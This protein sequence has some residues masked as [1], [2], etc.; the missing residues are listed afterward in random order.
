MPG[1]D[2]SSSNSSAIPPPSSTSPLKDD[3]PSPS[4]S[5]AKDSTATPVA[6]GVSQ[7]GAPEAKVGAAGVE[8]GEV[9]SSQDDDEPEADIGPASNEEVVDMEVF[10]QLLEIV[11][12]YL[13]YLSRTAPSR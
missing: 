9:I 13:A 8:T 4:N 2:A 1:P 12:S 5:L 7:A 11:R 3:D 6:P 10:G